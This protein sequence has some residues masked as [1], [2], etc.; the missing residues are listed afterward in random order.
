MTLPVQMKPRADADLE[1][2]G[3]HIAAENLDAAM[4]FLDAAEETIASL[5]AHPKR[6]A[7]VRSEHPLLQSIRWAPVKGF[8][9]YMVFYRAEDEQVLVI[10]VLHGARDLPGVLLKDEIL[11]G[12]DLDGVDLS[13]DQSPMRDPELLHQQEPATGGEHDEEKV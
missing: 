7:R 6:G 1:E 12:L 9:A 13:R 11:D 10:R 3:A 8:D 2:I 4:R 5:G